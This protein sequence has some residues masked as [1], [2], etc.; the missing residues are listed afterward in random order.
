MKKILFLTDFSE[1]ARDAIYFALKLFPPTDYEYLMLNCFRRTYTPS[2][3]KE[4]LNKTQYDDSQEALAREESIIH[5]F[6]G[7]DFGFKKISFL[8]SIGDGVNEVEDQH[9]VFMVV[10]G[11]KGAKNLSEILFGSNASSL[12]KYIDVPLLVVPPGKI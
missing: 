3:V 1:N 10:M 6:M 7:M 4:D 2:G 9:D 8:G 11:T 12:S 5:D